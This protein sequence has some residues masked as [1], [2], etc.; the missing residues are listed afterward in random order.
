MT[1]DTLVDLDGLE[2]REPMPGFRGRFVHTE[3]TTIVYWDVAAGAILPE[4]AHPHE[5]VSS[6]LDGVFDMTVDGVTHR[7]TA[8]TVSVI[9]PH[10]A[11][12]GRAIT[13]CR[14]IDVF[15]PVREDYRSHR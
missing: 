2:P 10:T 8:G 9:E 14:F 15:C 4:H 5:Q 7:M 6:L 13:D 11:H 3:R 12:S 1:A